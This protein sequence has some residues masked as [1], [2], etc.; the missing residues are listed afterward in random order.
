[1]SL[2]FRIAFKNHKHKFLLAITALAMCFLTLATQLEI[3]AFGVITTKGPDF[4]ELFAP[5]KGQTL[6]KT[7]TVSREDLD[8]RWNQLD[9]QH[10]GYVNKADAAT[11]LAQWKKKIFIDHAIA[12]LNEWLPVENN[13]SNLALLIVIVAMFKA[14]MLFVQRFATRL[15]GYSGQP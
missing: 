15:S 6:E 11:F 3:F 10:K 9:V 14:I 12:F 8:Q 5:V 4:F 1:M 13:I 2:L 7:A